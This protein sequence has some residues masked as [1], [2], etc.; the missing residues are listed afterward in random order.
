[1]VEAKSRAEPIH[2][3]TRALFYQ[4]DHSFAYLN[5]VKVQKTLAGM[6]ANKLEVLRYEDVHA[7]GIHFEIFNRAFGTKLYSSKGENS[8]PLHK[9][10]ECDRPHSKATS[11]S[12]PNERRKNMLAYFSSR[13]ITQLEN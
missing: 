13:R 6:P 2:T 12:M 11:K 7:F 1:M 10:S 8:P 5:E 3:I 4:D 9:M